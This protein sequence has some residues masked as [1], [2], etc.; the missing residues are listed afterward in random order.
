MTEPVLTVFTSTVYPDVA[1]LWHA[2]VRRAFPPGE[3]AVEIFYDAPDN[4]IRAEEFPG[5]TILRRTPTRREYH[6]AYNDAVRRAR[7]PYL[8]IVDSDVF[9]ISRGLWSRVREQLQRPEVAAVSC[10]SRSRRKSHGTYAV[11]MKV[12]AYREA[13]E[14]LP[15]GFNPAAEYLDADVPRE[16][17][18]WFD[19]GDIIAQAVR[20]A[21]H[22]ILFQ[23]LD[24]SGDLV[25]FY[26][27]TLTR[28]GGGFL[29]ARA[30]AEVAG[31][32]I[33]FW[34]GYISNLALKRLHDRIFPGVR[35]QFPF[36]LGPLIG[37]SFTR[38]LRLLWWRIGFARKI[39]SGARRVAA[40]IMEN[41][42]L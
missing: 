9:W 20:D 41:E 2:C 16:K 18:R 39:K 14:K 34:R 6:D 23:H 31:K 27:V 3:A 25:R 37:N 40:F 10:I 32:D 1:R 17:W 15:D 11:I 12:A 24:K 30:L 36:T 13:M 26:G 35:Y 8:A 7:T 5:A 19:T 29:G 33:Y 21:G 38:D 4:D 28:R 42:P 22:E